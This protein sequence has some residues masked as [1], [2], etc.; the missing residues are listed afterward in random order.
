LCHGV[1]QRL[2]RFQASCLY[3]RSQQRWGVLN[4]QKNVCRASQSSLLDAVTWGCPTDSAGELRA[5]ASL[6]FCSSICW[7]HTSTSRNKDSLLTV[8]QN[9][10]IEVCYRSGFFLPNHGKI[11]S[12]FILR[13]MFF[14]S[15]YTFTL[16]GLGNVSVGLSSWFLRVWRCF[17]DRLKLLGCGWSIG[18]SSGLL[19]TENKHRV[20]E[21]E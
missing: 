20:F 15:N 10:G 13:L 19:G 4:V 14:A 21:Q 11:I 5:E 8:L 6:P 3:R 16:S 2:L 1:V 9:A 18:R 17:G 7:S 12:V